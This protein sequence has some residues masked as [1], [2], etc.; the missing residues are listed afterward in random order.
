[1]NEFN[2][3]D[4]RAEVFAISL[5]SPM[6]AGDAATG[7]PSHG[8]YAEFADQRKRQNITVQFPGAS[9]QAL[10]PKAGPAKALGP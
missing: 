8:Q 5:S 3:A 7:L 6:M 1:M 4:K 2:A 10:R 9:P